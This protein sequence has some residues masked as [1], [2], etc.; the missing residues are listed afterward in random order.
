MK[1]KNINQVRIGAVMSYINMAIG[2]LIPMFYTPLMLSLLGQ[3]EYGLYKL[4][5]S[6]T[7]YL[8]ILTFG[9]GSALVRY[10]TK[11][12]AIG[13]KNGEENMYGLFTIIFGIISGITML[14][15]IVMCIV[16]PSI[17]SDSLTKDG[18]L[19]KF[20]VLILIIS[21][22]TALSFLMSPCCSIVNSHEK[23]IF[24]QMVNTS[25]TIIIPI[26]NIIVLY[27]GCASIGIA[28]SSL[29]I[30]SIS[31]L[32][33]I[34]Y[35]SKK[36]NIKPKY[37]NLPKHLLKEMMSFSVFIFLM[38]IIDKLYSTTDTMIIGYIPS[39]ATMGVAVY[40]IGI[41]FHNM[42]NSFSSGLTSVITPKINMMV[43]GDNKMDDLTDAMI[44]VGRLQCY[45]VSL[46]M[47]GFIAF[48][49]QF[50][51]LWVGDTY[52]EAYWVALAVTIP[53]CIP[54]VQTVAF[55]VI[56]AQN[57][58]KFRTVVFLIIA[59][60]NVIGTYFCVN[61]FGI[62]GAAVVTGITYILGQGLVM[63]WYY[64]KKIGLNMPKFW[65]NI[66][67]MF[68]FPTI[69]CIVSLIIFNY[70]ILDSWAVLFVG[71]LVYTLV[72][73]VF[74]W[75][76]TMNDYEKDIFRVP[77]K[78]ILKLFRRKSEDNR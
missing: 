50:I 64:W 35:V 63:N 40:S 24:L 25:T 28:L 4:A 39:L 26:V 43:F 56:I 12:R 8:S 45:I 74:S 68:I 14:V 2:S 61:K 48:G 76:F 54:L 78:K 32:F 7:S 57:K 44:K 55:S 15:G 22:N 51:I 60:L 62:I 59:V 71:V 73:L 33:Y 38:S 1:N 53:V 66:G 58:L 72:F 34:L 18:Q 9:F 19:F 23:F 52:S 10:Y 47:S 42:I 77:L 65:K 21:I 30:S 37:N 49:Y 67:P 20:Q 17:Y 75:I 41:T 69:L 3:D 29:V 31:N 13:D 70:I 27:F 5:S 36:M 11:Y 46:I 6:I 16:A